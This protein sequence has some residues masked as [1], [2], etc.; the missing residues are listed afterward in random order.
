[1]RLKARLTKLENGGV[2]DF[3]QVAEALNTIAARMG[4]APPFDLKPGGKIIGSRQDYERFLM[5]TGELAKRDEE[6]QLIR[7]MSDDEL[8]TLAKSA[9]GGSGT[10]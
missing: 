5:T 2:I 9:F 3:T 4:Q 1:M 10:A 8:I 7:S 6:D